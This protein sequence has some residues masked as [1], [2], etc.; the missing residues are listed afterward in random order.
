MITRKYFCLFVSV[1]TKKDGNKVTITFSHLNQ[2]FPN[3]SSLL[4]DLS[5]FIKKINH[6]VYIHITDLNIDI[7]WFLKKS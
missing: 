7:K 5:T 6:N 4:I 1:L 2:I 3:S